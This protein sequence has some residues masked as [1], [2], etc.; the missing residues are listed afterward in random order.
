MT[1]EKYDGWVTTEEYDGWVTT[2]EVKGP[3][4]VH[5]DGESRLRRA[6][7]EGESVSPDWV[8]LSFSGG[9]FAQGEQE[10]Q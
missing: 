3:Q 8:S 9:A 1:T 10:A 7:G 5:N 4:R 2:E 6:V